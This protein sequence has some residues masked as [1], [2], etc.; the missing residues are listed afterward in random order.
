MTLGKNYDFE[1]YFLDLA[2]QLKHLEVTR[3]R[4]T[5]Q[6]MNFQFASILQFL[7]Q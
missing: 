5:Q 7:K 1:P 4:F 2:R 3:G 6:T